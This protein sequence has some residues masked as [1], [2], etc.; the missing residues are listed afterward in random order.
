MQSLCTLRDHCRQGPRN[1]R[2]QADATPYLG[3]TSTGWIAPACGWR[4]YSI[5]SSARISRAA[6]TGAFAHA[7]DILHIP[8]N[9]SRGEHAYKGFHIQN[10]N[11]YTSRLKDWLRPFKGVASWYLLSYL[12]WRRAIERLG[13]NLQNAACRSPIVVAQHESRTEPKHLLNVRGGIPNRKPMRRA[14]PSSC[15]LPQ[16][17]GGSASALTLSRPARAS[18]TLRPAVSLS[19]PRRPLS[20]GSDPTSYQAKPLASFRTY[21]QLSGWNPPPLMIRA[22]GAH[23]Q[24]RSWTDDAVIDHRW[25]DTTVPPPWNRTERGYR[26]HASGASDRLPPLH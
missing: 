24:C 25:H 10:V 2:Y 13:D 18:H 22:F 19:R 9:T 17:A 15:S 12:G 21:R 26:Q 4:T 20:R 16:M 1:T 7:E 11:A 3:R 5:T 14:L 23:C 6:G 8:I